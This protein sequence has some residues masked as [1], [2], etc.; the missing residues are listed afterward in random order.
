MSSRGSSQPRNETQVSC[1]MGRF[2]TIWATREVHNGYVII[3]LF[4]IGEYC[5][6]YFLTHKNNWWTS[7][8]VQWLRLYASIAGG[9]SSIPDQETKIPHT[10]QH[11]HPPT[12]GREIHMCQKYICTL[13]PLASP[14]YCYVLFFKT[15]LSVGK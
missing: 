14:N 8:A 15:A 7:L 1:I 4:S 5:K 12:E 11:S 10:S 6:K 3:Q 13:L 2:F 9:T